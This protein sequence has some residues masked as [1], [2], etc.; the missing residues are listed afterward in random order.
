MDFSSMISTIDIGTL[1][2]AFTAIA[3]LKLVPG[4]TKWAYN[5]VINWFSSYDEASAEARAEDAYRNYRDDDDD[6]DAQH[7]NQHY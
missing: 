4:F 1:I 7:R 6:T 5:K 3:S 2:A